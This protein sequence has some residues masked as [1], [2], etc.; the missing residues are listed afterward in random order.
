MVKFIWAQDKNGLIGSKGRMPWRNKEEINFFKNQTTGGIVVMGYKTWKSMNFTPL[1]NRINIILSHN[2]T[3][4]VNNNTD[5]DTNDIVKLVHSVEE[6]INVY[7]N[8][9]R[10]MWII[11]G[12]SVFKQF[13][14]YCTE[15][16]VS[17]IDGDYKGDTYYKGL[18][19]KLIDENVVVTMEGDGFTVRHYK[20]K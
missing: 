16:I 18:K 10:D 7:N 11:G 15:A 4:K 5:K 20:V 9:D 6:V 14:D 3:V 13:E 12:S 8:S 19:D 17:T 2:K 1:K